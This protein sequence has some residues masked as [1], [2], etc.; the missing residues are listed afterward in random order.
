MEKYTVAISFFNSNDEFKKK[1]FLKLSVKQAERLNNGFQ[2]AQEQ[3]LIYGLTMFKQVYTYSVGI[4]YI[5]QGRCITRI[6]HK[7]TNKRVEQLKA[8][9]D[10]AKSNN[11]ISYLN[12]RVL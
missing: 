6:F 2:S 11:V 8:I 1:I 4:G 3:G 5:K 12:F 10:K 9:Y 7:L